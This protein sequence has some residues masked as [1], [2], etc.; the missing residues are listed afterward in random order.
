M[1]RTVCAVRLSFCFVLPRRI[2]IWF[3]HPNLSILFSGLDPSGLLSG[4]PEGA[5]WYCLFRPCSSTTGASGPMWPSCSCPPPSTI[6]TVCWWSGARTKATTKGPGWRWP[7]PSSSTW[8]AAVLQVLGLPGRFLQAMGLTFMPGGCPSAFRYLLLYLPNH[9]LHHRR[10]PGDTRAQRSII[11]F[12]TFVTLFPSSSPVPSSS[13]RTWATRSTS[14]P[15]LPRS[16][17]PACRCLWSAW[18]KGAD[19]QQRG[20][21]VGGL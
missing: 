21:A 14:A 18:A 20:H 13:T 9:E 12:G 11:N 1:G 3:F 10:V 16:L 4:A 7:R 8:P 19:G 5:T 17:P 15:P 6:P 2:T